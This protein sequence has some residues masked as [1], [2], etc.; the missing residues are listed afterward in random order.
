MP[1]VSVA[2]AVA[3]AS[4]G[5]NVRAIQMHASRQQPQSKI[6]GPR[7][8]GQPA[9]PSSPANNQTKQNKKEARQYRNSENK[10]TRNPGG[11]CAGVWSCGHTVH[12]AAVPAVRGLLSSTHEC[13]L[14]VQGNPWLGCFG[15]SPGSSRHWHWRQKNTATTRHAGCWLSW[16]HQHLIPSDLI[17]MTAGLT[18][19]LLAMRNSGVTCCVQLQIKPH[20]RM[21]G[22]GPGL[23]P[24]EARNLLRAWLDLGFLGVGVGLHPGIYRHCSGL[25]VCLCLL[26]GPSTSPSASCLVLAWLCW[27]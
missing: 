21:V 22:V 8:A 25:E 20:R 1:M 5:A 24:E 26:L 4:A 23:I 27:P 10:N 6:F 19:Q 15:N 11:G 3:S 18:S 12:Q 7:E 16:W 14:V 9:G 17:A 2:G 13:V